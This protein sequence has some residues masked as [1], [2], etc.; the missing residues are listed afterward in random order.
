MCWVIVIHDFQ[1]V[2]G[3]VIPES[4]HQPL[5][6]LESNDQ[7]ANG[8]TQTQNMPTCMQASIEGS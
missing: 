5:Q 8:P 6:K 4:G 7:P 1:I 2:D 3:A